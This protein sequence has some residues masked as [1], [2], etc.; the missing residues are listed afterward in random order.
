MRL[1]AGIETNKTNEPSLAIDDVVSGVESTDPPWSE[2]VIIDSSVMK[3][4][5]AVR[6]VEFPIPLWKE[7]GTIFKIPNI[8][9]LPT[10][11]MA[12][13]VNLGIGIDDNAC[14]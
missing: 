4:T 9:L 7:K 6:R 1:G 2:R 5:A 10:T 3:V 12:V 14:R 8:T 13:V 11:E